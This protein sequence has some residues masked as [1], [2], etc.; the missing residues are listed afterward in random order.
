[1]IGIYHSIADAAEKYG[2]KGNYVMGA[3]L[4]AFEKIAE[5]MMAHGVC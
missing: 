4:A 5:A 2:Q 3:N 1:M